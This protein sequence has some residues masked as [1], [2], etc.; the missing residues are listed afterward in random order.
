MKKDEDIYTTDD[1]RLAA[2]VCFNA[3]ETTWGY[4]VMVSLNGVELNT[5]RYDTREEAEAMAEVWVKT[6]E[7]VA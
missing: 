6:M 4:Y 5:T 7:V 1:G 2:A 3:S